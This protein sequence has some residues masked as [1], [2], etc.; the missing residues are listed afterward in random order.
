[1]EG[2]LK[3]RGIKKK[4]NLEISLIEGNYEDNE[5]IFLIKGK[6]NRNDFEA[7]GYPNLVKKEIFLKSKIHIKSQF[8][9]EK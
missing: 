9:L 3:L 5:L 1:M 8:N 7:G 4:I 2:Y 6:F